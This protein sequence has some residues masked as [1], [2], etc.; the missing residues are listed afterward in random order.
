MHVEF[1]PWQTSLLGFL[2]FINIESESATAVKVTERPFL[3]KWSQSLPQSIP[4]GTEVTLPVPEPSL[5]TCSFTPQRESFVS[6]Q[7]PPKQFRNGLQSL[8]GSSSQSFVKSGPIAV[9]DPFS[10]KAGLKTFLQY[11][12]AS[13]GCTHS[14]PWQLLQFPVSGISHFPIPEGG[15]FLP[16]GTCQIGPPFTAN[17][18]HRSI[19]P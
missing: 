19:H 13:R 17:V 1:V 4:S 9:I 10:S 12:S 11:L 3:N 18:F 14:V 6:L 7:L 5:E 8:M 15:M 2:H 16:G